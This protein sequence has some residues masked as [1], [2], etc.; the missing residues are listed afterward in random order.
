MIGRYTQLLA[1]AILGIVHRGD[2]DCVSKTELQ[3]AEQ[4]RFIKGTPPVNPVNAASRS[5]EGAG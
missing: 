1:A 5:N 3:A 4:R 2:C